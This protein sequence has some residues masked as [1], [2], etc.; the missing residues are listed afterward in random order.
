MNIPRSLF[1]ILGWNVHT[2]DIHTY[3]HTY[4]HTTHTYM[5]LSGWWYEKKVRKGKEVWE[6]EENKDEDGRKSEGNG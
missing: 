1:D 3:I 5:A 4:I 6:D 2:K